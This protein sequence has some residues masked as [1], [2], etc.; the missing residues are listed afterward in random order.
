MILSVHSANL[1]VTLRIPLSK[2][3]FCVMF[4]HQ[5]SMLTI[6]ALLIRAPPTPIQYPKVANTLLRPPYNPALYRV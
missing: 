6:P 2:K 4:L 1:H 3:V 5:C